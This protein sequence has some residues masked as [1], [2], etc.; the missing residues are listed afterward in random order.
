MQRKKST[1]TESP[2]EMN[3]KILEAA[4]IAMEMPGKSDEKRQELIARIFA[5]AEAP[6]I[7]VS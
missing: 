6:Q 3:D 5:N 1:K 4:L 7:A 2:K